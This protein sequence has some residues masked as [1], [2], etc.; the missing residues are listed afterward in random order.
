MVVGAGGGSLVGGDGGGSLVARMC[1]DLPLTILFLHFSMNAG[2]IISEV[3][4]LSAPSCFI[5][6]GRQ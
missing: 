2:A 3:C 4:S 6:G 1:F 5:H